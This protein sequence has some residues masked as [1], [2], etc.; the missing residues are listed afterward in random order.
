MFLDGLEDAYDKGRLMGTFAED[1]RAALP[2]HARGAGRLRHREPEARQGGQ[3]GRLVR[4]GD[5]ARGGE[6]ALGRDRGRRATSSR[7]RPIPRKIPKL[8]PA[9]RDGG[10]VTAANSSSISDGAA[11]LVLMRE[12]EA[13]R[14]KLA[15]ARQ[16]RGRRQRRP[17]AG[18]V[19]HRAGRRHQEAARGRSAGAPRTS[20]STR[21]TRR[22]RS[23]PWR[24][25]ATSALPHEKVNVHG[26]ACA[27]GHPDRRLRRAHP[28]H[29]ARA[30]WRST[31]RARA[32]PRCASAAARRRRSPSSAWREDDPHR[33]RHRRA[34]SEG[35]GRPDRHRHVGR[36]ESVRA[37]S[38]GRLR[39][40]NAW[41]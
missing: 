34:G 11:A 39:S 28:R 1:M 19:H 7:S 6:G 33:D 23:S 30:P 12:S 15:A 35:V 21:S 40:A 29:A 25:C 18:L 5:R 17:G 22:S 10:T 32:S 4:Q 38:S 26:G 2:V 24:P 14:R 3:R 27:L 20:A 16:D 9:F 41:R 31:A 37:R 36:M 8:K 13:K